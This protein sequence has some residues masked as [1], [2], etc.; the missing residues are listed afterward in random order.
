MRSSV[1]AA[2]R[3]ARSAASKIHGVQLQK[4]SR[5]IVIFDIHKSDYIIPS[6]WLV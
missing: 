6:V 5:G 1:S 4:L 2:H 3:R